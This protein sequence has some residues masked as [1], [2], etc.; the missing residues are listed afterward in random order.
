VLSAELLK[1]VRQ[2]HIKTS[3][4]VDAAFAGT[5]QSAFRGQGMEFQEVRQYVPGDDV[6]SI[7]WNVT[8]KTGIPHIKIFQEERELTV[9]LMLDM[10]ASGLFAST[11]QLKR[12]LIAEIAAVLAFSAIRNND[13]VGVIL[14]TDHV[15]KIMLPKKGR[16]HVWQVIREIL[17][18][19]SNS[20]G[21]NISQALAVLNRLSTRKAICFLLSDFIDNKPYERELTAACGRH[22]VVSLIINDTHETHL[23]NVGILNVIDPETGKTAAL[24]TA[25]KKQR[26]HIEKLFDE[27]YQQIGKSISKAGGRHLFVNE[28]DDYIHK[29]VELFQKRRAR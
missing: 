7:D 9:M 16:G 18:F 19:K 14:F 10:S 11:N 6:R 5:Y 25:S 12:N 1:K 8:A 2:L 23:P 3:H 21:T 28:R 15:E 4:L 13:K 29:L 17:T 27:K 24:N 20:R 26:L 22:D